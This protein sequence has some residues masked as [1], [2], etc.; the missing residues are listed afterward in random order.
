MFLKYDTIFIAEGDLRRYE[1]EDGY[2]YLPDYIAV[3]TIDKDTYE[4]PHYFKTDAEALSFIGTVEKFGT[5]NSDVWKK[6]NPE[7]RYSNGNDEP[8]D[9]EERY[10]LGV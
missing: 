7:Y 10:Y 9:E 1:T 5:I 3:I 6:Y 4:H 2:T 8:Y